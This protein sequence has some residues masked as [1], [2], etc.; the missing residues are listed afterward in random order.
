MMISVMLWPMSADWMAGAAM[1]AASVTVIATLQGVARARMQWTIP[2]AL[3]F[4]A[5]NGSLLAQTPSPRH[6]SAERIRPPPC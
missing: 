6:N 2:I 1:V 4:G 3:V 5:L